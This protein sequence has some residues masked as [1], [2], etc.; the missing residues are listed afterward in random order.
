MAKRLTEKIF[1]LDISHPMIQQKIKKQLKLR[2]AQINT[3]LNRSVKYFITDQPKN[4]ISSTCKT[5]SQS[6]KKQLSKTPLPLPVL[7]SQKIFN[8]NKARKFGS[9]IVS[10]C[11]IQKWFNLYDPLK[12]NNYKTKNN[13]REREKERTAHQTRRNAFDS[14]T[15]TTP[16]FSKTKLLNGKRSTNTKTQKKTKILQ[17]ANKRRSILKIKMNTTNINNNR[18][19]LQTQKKKLQIVNKNSIYIRIEDKQSD[20]RPIKKRFPQNKIK[21]TSFFL[22]QRSSRRLY[23]LGQVIGEPGQERKLRQKR[24]LKHKK[25]RRKIKG[26]GYCENCKV[27]YSNFENHCQSKEHQRF[28]KNSKSFEKA[29]NFI[30]KIENMFQNEK[31]LIIENLQKTNREKKKENDNN[32][33]LLSPSLSLLCEETPLSTNINYDFNCPTTITNNNLKININNNITANTNSK[34]IT[35]INYKNFNTTTTATFL[36]L[37]DRVDEWY[38]PNYQ[39]HIYPLIDET[40]ITKKKIE[41]I[42]I[43]DDSLNRKDQEMLEDSDDVFATGFQPKNNRKRKKPRKNKN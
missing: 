10:V 20:Y 19:S 8:I 3:A 11:C 12:N 32:K 4:I 7:F 33:N 14:L 34:T 9:R 31:K 22:Q 27:K 17:N 41:P 16:L 43:F 23:N 2:G 30:E 29:D 28:C 21:T 6:P 37:T 38:S 39:N 36:T 40:E 15:N 5:N 42:I 25:R 13:Q 1:Y 24:R 18:N 35:N 26:S